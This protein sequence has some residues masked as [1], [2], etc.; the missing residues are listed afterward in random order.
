[1]LKKEIVVRSCVPERATGERKKTVLAE[2]CG[3]KDVG[4]RV[5][6]AQRER[7]EAV[8]AREQRDQDEGSDYKDQSN[9]RKNDPCAPAGSEPA[10]RRRR[11]QQDGGNQDR[12]GPRSAHACAK[13][14]EGHQDQG[15]LDHPDP[16]R[17]PGFVPS[18]PV[19]EEEGRQPPA[20]QVRCEQARKPV[21]DVVDHGRRSSRWGPTPSAVLPVKCPTR[22]SAPSPRTGM[23]A[24]DSRGSKF[25]PVGS[26]I[27]HSRALISQIASLQ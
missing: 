24:D 18:E 11:N 17:E 5:V 19:R 21:D 8:P 26:A 12:G 20:E 7:V 9:G 3:G 15:R 23:S 25:L 27:G 14:A 13:G 4:K 1:M 22:I 10:S 2:P 16:G 6:V